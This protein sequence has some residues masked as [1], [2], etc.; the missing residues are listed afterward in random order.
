MFRSFR[1]RAFQTN[2]LSQAQIQAL[3]NANRFVENGQPAKAAPI[4][5]ELAKELET[6]NHPR[7]AAN[8]RAQAA[9][10]FADSHNGQSALANARAALTL[11]IQNQMVERTPVFYTNIIRKLNNYGMKEA[12]AALMTEFSSIVV[13]VPVPSSPKPQTHSRLPTNC[14]KCGGPVHS[15]EANWVDASTVECGYCG[16]MIRP[17]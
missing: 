2:P 9:H 4:F 17:E 13:S 7:R 8:L 3:N 1:N 11:F 6:S 5:A 12:S 10:A 14:P 16:A 15:D